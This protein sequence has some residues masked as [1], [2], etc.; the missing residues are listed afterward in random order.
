[1][2]IGAKT[3]CHQR[4]DRSFFVWNH[5]FPVCARCTGVVIGYIVA[6]VVFI[7]CMIPL[8]LCALLCLIMFLDWLIQYLKIKESNNIRR[9]VTGVLGGYGLLSFEINLMAIVICYF[10]VK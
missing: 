5:Q 4:P 10:A 3:G 9:F 1:M 8:W 2:K 6:L 7:F